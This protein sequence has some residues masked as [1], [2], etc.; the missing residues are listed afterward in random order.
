MSRHLTQRFAIG[1]VTR[2]RPSSARGTDSVRVATNAS[3]R[4][5]P[6]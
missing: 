5:G 6:P 2:A 3:V 1:Y 4:W